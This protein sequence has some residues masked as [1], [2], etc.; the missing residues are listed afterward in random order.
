MG[1]GDLLVF[2]LDAVDIGWLQVLREQAGDDALVVA[3]TGDAAFVC[4]GI[5]GAYFGAGMGILI[6]AALGSFLPIGLHVANAW[7]NLL[8]LLIGITATSILIFTGMVH[9]PAALAI[10]AASSMGAV[11]GVSLARRLP[12]AA[13][14]WFT[15][16]IGVALAAALAFAG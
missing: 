15:V 11:A 5:Y 10:A 13:I 12:A 1:G 16:A 3:R 8:S 4:C 9:W 14:R 6:M 2:G 7:K